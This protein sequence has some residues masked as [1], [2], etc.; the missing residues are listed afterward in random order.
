MP[1]RWVDG[2][3]ELRRWQEVENRGGGLEEE[4]TGRQMEE[5]DVDS[6]LY[7]LTA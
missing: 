3:I 5:R 4:G 2:K 6:C 7:I 1:G